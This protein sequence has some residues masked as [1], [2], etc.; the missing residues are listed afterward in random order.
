M[1]RLDRAPAAP[2]TVDITRPNAARIY[3]W[4]LG[5]AANY[6]IDREF[7]AKVVELWPH[8]RGVARQNRGFLRRVVIN[9]LDAGVRQFLDLGSGVPTVGNVHQIARHHLTPDQQARV[10]YVD[11]EHV[12]VTHARQLLDEEGATGWAGVVQADLRV[13]PRVLGDPLTT[14]LLD[15]HQPVCLM[16]VAVLHFVGGDDNVP[17]LLDEYARRLAPGSWLVLSHI[18]SDEAGTEDQAAVEAFRQAYDN[19]SNPLWVR[20]YGEVYGWF[21]SMDGWDLLDP[22]VVHLS[23]WRPETDTC[24]EDPVLR[25]FAWCGVAGKVRS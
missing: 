10:V 21:R 24:P 20:D 2:S 18:A 25:P 13:P 7:G 19:T 15:L 11:Y 6:V 4:Y 5:G 12:A 3:D 1:R 17:H 14:R 9:A 23:D 16:L 8:V 22:G